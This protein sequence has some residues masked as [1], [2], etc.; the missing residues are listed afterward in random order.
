MTNVRSLETPRSEPDAE[1]I[2]RLE[3]LLEQ[4]KSGE[5]HRVAYVTESQ[6]GGFIYGTAGG[7]TVIT[8]GTVNLLRDYVSNTLDCHLED[9]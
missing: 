5:I 7:I 8:L 2:S 9:L 3:N 1:V 6:N 4:A